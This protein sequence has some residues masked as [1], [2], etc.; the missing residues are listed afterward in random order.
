MLSERA[1]GVWNRSIVAGVDPHQFLF[2][3]VI[4]GFIIIFIQF[5]EISWCGFFLL[6][7]DTM[8]WSSMAMMLM[9]LFLTGI[10]GLMVATIISVAFESIEP[11]LQVSCGFLISLAFISGYFWPIQ[12]MPKPMQNFAFLFSLAVPAKAL[13]N[14]VYKNAT[15]ADFD[16]Q[17]AILILVFWIW[18]LK[19]LAFWM[20]RRKSELKCIKP[21]K[22]LRTLKL[23]YK[24][25]FTK[26]S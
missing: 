10:L 13:R 23:L 12:G 14:V 5:I 17:M 4:E 7:L 3:H 15:L 18:M 2:S 21:L 9:I 22:I 16:V 6:D 26:V 25:K 1:S 8:S 11:A 24:N 20:L 19:T